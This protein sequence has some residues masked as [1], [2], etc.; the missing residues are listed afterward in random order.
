MNIK[1]FVINLERRLDR[2]NKL[3]IPL[4]NEINKDDCMKVD[5]IFSSIQKQ[6][7]CYITS[8]ILCW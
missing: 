2:L 5:V 4:L 8:P 3:K 1:T 7:K 6:N